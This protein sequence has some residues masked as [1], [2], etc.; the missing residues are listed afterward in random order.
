MLRLPCAW[1]ESLLYRLLLHPSPFT[2]RSPL[3]PAR[4]PH[5][6][7]LHSMLRDRTL[8]LHSSRYFFFLT[9]ILPI[10]NIDLNTWFW[11]LLE[12][13]MTLGKKAFFFF[14]TLCRLE[15]DTCHLTPSRWKRTINFGLRKVTIRPANY[16]CKLNRLST[17]DARSPLIVIIIIVL[18]IT[19]VM[20]ERKGEVINRRDN[21]MTAIVREK[22]RRWRIVKRDASPIAACYR[23]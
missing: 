5:R 4:K 10:I 9:I 17:I 23:R 11:N 16:A 8:F 13:K 7:A 19:P 6:L 21:I 20:R 18:I 22:W 2:E 1:W 14:Y 15:K 12:A 3:R